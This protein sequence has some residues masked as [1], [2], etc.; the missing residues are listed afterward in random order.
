MLGFKKFADHWFGSW[1]I[2][3]LSV[4]AFIIVIKVLMSKAPNTG[5]IGAGKAAVNIV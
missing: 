1:V 2:N 3:G 5:A 4:V